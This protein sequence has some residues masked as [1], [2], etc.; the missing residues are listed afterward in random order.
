MARVMIVEDEPA[1]S[2]LLAINLKLVGHSPIC[3]DNG[4]HVIDKINE[5]NPDLILLD[6][7]LP[8]KDGFELMKEIHPLDIP[9][10][11]LTAK[12]NIDDKIFGLKLGADD[13]IV[14]PFITIEVLTRI[15]TVLKRCNKTGNI[16]KLNNLE[17][18]F[19]EHIVTLNHEQ[20]DLTIKEYELLEA[21][22]RN[23]NI[24]L[25]RERL[26]EI[27]WGFDYIGETRTVDVHIQKLRKKLNLE[28]IIK[29]I[30]KVG[31]RLE[32]RE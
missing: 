26:L 29:T 6:V 13:Y 16:F 2:D 28:D 10:I 17:V 1:I 24:A 20:I 18:R 12:E 8:G 4:N 31:Y 9:V 14:K 27:I 23:K 19:D 30:F 25:S 15:D 22:I 7:M 3:C 32:V 5:T 21:L 11:F